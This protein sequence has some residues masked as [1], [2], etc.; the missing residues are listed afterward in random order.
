MSGITFNPPN[1]DAEAPAAP[2]PADEVR[3]SAFWPAVNITA[4]REA[5]RLDTNITP[6]RLR[7][8]VR[9]AMLD[10][11]GELAAWR[12]EQEALGFTRLE[13]V[14]ARLQVDGVSDYL[15]RFNR[16]IYSVVAADLAER[17]I[18]SALAAAGAER[19]EQLRE[20]VDV[21]MRNVRYA[22]RD[23]LGRPR[24]RVALV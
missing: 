21:H 6:G 15:M 11:A 9:L 12:A 3:L 22:V 17:Q 4:V 23:F 16:A 13:D 18:G 19:A 1:A 20:D 10:V 14:P 2:A 7:D 5:A 8:A 24:A